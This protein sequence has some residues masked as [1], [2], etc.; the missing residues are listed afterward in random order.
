MRTVKPSDSKPIDNN[1]EQNS[2]ITYKSKTFHSIQYLKT[3]G[4]SVDGQDSSNSKVDGGLG[5]GRLG[6]ALSV[7]YT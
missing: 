7:S 3:D 6:I 2:N 4:F 5:V 1:V